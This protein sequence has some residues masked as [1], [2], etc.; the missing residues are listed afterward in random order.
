MV[1][2]E[3]LCEYPPNKGL[4]WEDLEIDHSYDDKLCERKLKP[5]H[6]NAWFLRNIE[7]YNE[8]MSKYRLIYSDGSEDFIK[9][10]D[11]D[12]VEIMLID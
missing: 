12:G 6:D 2:I 10:E 9:V 5:L 4:E 3:L 8:T 1:E 7:Y 11:I